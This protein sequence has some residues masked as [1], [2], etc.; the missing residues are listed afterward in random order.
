MCYLMIDKQCRGALMQK[1]FLQKPLAFVLRMKPQSAKQS[2]FLARTFASLVLSKR[3]CGLQI[4]Q[5]A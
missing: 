2:E 1:V 5:F 4:A 3:R